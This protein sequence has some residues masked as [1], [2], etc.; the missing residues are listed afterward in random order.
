MYDIGGDFAGFT[1][2]LILGGGLLKLVNDLKKQGLKATVDIAQDKGK[3]AIKKL[4]FVAGTLILTEKGFKP[5]EEIQVGDKVWS[6]NEVTKETELKEVVALSR[7]TTS[8]LIEITAGNETIVCTPEHPFYIGD[9]WIEAKNLNIGDNLTLK[10]N[11]FVKISNLNH[12]EKEVTVYNFEVAENHNYY[13]SE[14]EVLVHN[15]C[16]GTIVKGGN[17]PSKGPELAKKLG[18]D[19]DVWHNSNGTGLKDKLKKDLGF[20]S[21]KKVQDKYGKNPDFGLSDDGKQLLFK[22][23]H[24]NLK[25][26]TFDTGLSIEQMKAMIK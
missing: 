23:T 11:T 16:F 13:V 26:K 21:N 4:C 24:G 18:I 9:K 5:I 19:A 20:E 15:D 12:L 1:L 10:N 25:G 6:Y 14:L 3:Q 8:Q 2:G 22:P 17:F 7:N